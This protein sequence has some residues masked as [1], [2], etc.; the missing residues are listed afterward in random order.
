MIN[1]IR[2]PV[3]RFISKFYYKRQYEEF[4]VKMDDAQIDMVRAGMVIMIKEYEKFD[5]K[6]CAWK[7]SMT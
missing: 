4:K 1:L 6:V 5:I 3:S 7:I 2:N